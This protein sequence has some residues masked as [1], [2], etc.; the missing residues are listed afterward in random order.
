MNKQE[1]N[2][3]WYLKNRDKIL[4]KNKEKAM[5][6]AIEQMKTDIPFI[7]NQKRNTWI[8]ISDIPEDVFKEVWGYIETDKVLLDV[9]YQK[10]KII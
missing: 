1:S 6:K 2:R 10:F 3:Q 7:N 9:D 8:K 4:S 5:Q